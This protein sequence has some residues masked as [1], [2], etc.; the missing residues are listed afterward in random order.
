MTLLGWRCGAFTSAMMHLQF[1]GAPYVHSPCSDADSSRSMKSRR[2]K[3]DCDVIAYVPSDFLQVTS[4]SRLSLSEWW[5][6]G[7]LR[8][9]F[10]PGVVAL[11]NCCASRDRTKC[12][13]S[14]RPVILSHCLSCAHNSLGFDS[15]L[16]HSGDAKATAPTVSP[17]VILSAFEWLAI[18]ESGQYV[19]SS[20]A[21][22]TDVIMLYRP[23]YLT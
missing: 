21:L 18:D 7:R 19:P 17:S 16:L 20:T 3:M 9:K 4:L 23:I 6:Q 11:L 2:S 13:N 14:A 5:A 15:I 1:R 22:L 10:S 8:L 12:L